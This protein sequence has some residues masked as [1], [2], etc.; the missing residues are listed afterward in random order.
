MSHIESQ[1]HRVQENMRAAI[2]TMRN[3]LDDAERRM[4]QGTLDY[5][6]HQVMHALSWG[7]VNATN[8]MTTAMAALEDFNAAKLC[9]LEETKNDR[10]RALEDYIKVLQ[11]GE[12][13]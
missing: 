5:S 11:E 2:A 6:V 12:A 9:D 3:A 8:S 13:K 10:I 7:Y 4:T 1:K